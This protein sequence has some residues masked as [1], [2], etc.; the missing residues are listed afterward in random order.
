MGGGTSTYWMVKILHGKPPGQLPTL[1]HEAPGL[2]FEPAT[3]EVEGEHSNR[4]TIESPY[5]LQENN[6]I[7]SLIEDQPLLC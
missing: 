4:Y 1:Q 2:R 7:G 6:L 5:Y 3:S